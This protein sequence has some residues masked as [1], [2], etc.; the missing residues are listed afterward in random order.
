MSIEG[1]LVV[2]STCSGKHGVPF[3]FRWGSGDTSRVATGESGLLS[4]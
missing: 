4:S 2:L 3:E 1:E